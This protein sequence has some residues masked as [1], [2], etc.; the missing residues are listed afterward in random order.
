MVEGEGEEATDGRT[1]KPT[2]GQMKEGAE[3]LSGVLQ[4]IFHFGAVRIKEDA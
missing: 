2:Y 1:D 3:F 4:N